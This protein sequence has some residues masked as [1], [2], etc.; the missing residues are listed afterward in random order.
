[1]KGVGQPERKAKRSQRCLKAHPLLILQATFHGF[2]A[3]H[4]HQI[5]SPATEPGFLL[6]EEGLKSPG[7]APGF[8]FQQETQLQPG[9][10]LTG[11]PG[12]C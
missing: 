6:P 9:Q 4:L 1:M 7:Q 12:H 8:L 2:S 10:A 5:P 3:G 11:Q